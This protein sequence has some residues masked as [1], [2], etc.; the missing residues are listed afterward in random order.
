MSKYIYFGLLGFLGVGAVFGGIVLILSPSGE[1]FQMPLSLLDNSPFS[2]F[3]I[4]GLILFLVLGVIPLAVVWA[5]LYRP[6]SKVLERLN[7]FS[8][9]Y[10][11]WSFSIYVAF[12]LILWIQMEMI[13]LQ[14]IHWSHTLYM[15][16]AIA[17]IFIALLPSIRKLYTLK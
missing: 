8:D 16:W 6:S 1:W 11:G 2:D 7:F 13:Y 12:A 17:I 14:S 4:P 5:L 3:L 15:V 9:M 10:W